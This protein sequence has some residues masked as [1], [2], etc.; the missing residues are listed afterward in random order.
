MTGGGSWARG[1]TEVRW[2]SGGALWVRSARATLL[3]DAPPGVERTLPDASVDHLVLTSG[4]LE[5]LGGLLGLFA[6]VDG[7]GEPLDVQVIL[8]D[9]RASALADAWSRHWPRSREVEVDARRPGTY[10]LP[11]FVVTTI[12]L[13]GA[14]ELGGRVSPVPVVGVRIRTPD[15]T[16]AFAPRC[17]AGTTLARVLGGAD[18]AVATVGGPPGW[19]TDPAAAGRAGATWVADPGPPGSASAGEVS[20][21][22][23]QIDLTASFS[24]PPERLWAAWVDGAGH[25]AMTG[26][27][28]TSDPR[29]GGAFTAWD[30]YITGT[31][32]ELAPGRSLVMAWRTSQFP[33]DAPSA[34]VEVELRAEAGGTALRLRQ[35]STPADQVDAYTQGWEEH[36]FRPMRAHLR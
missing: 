10:P 11:P 36:Y 29:V 15:A 7:P 25:A 19:S 3:I 17:R 21:S 33:A 2:L 30:G 14:E 5:A 35:S 24:V 1:G 9:E 13:A 22:D 26:A 20:V 6:A 34:R 28:A 27:G 32:L 18:L 8:G 16:I 31:W 4:R 12:E 23:P